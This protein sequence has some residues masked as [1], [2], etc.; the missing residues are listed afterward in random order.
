MLSTLATAEF[1]YHGHSS[2]TAAGQPSANMSLGNGLKPCAPAIPLADR[3]L[4][5]FRVSLP[6][7]EAMSSSRVGTSARGQWLCELQLFLQAQ[8][9]S[10][11]VGR[12]A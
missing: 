9:G 5:R 11:P 2:E 7:P 8:S 1:R 3:V 6:L 12:S 4:R 10:A